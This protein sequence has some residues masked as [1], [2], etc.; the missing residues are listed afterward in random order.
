[1][2]GGQLQEL[3]LLPLAALAMA[4]IMGL[5]P[6][7]RAVMII[8]AAMPVAGNVYMLAAHYGLAPQRVSS[9]ILISTA[10]SILTLPPVLH[11][12]LP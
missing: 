3:V 9:A 5:D 4:G 6:Q 7:V 11:W 1:M 10:V 12:M 8:Y 2:P